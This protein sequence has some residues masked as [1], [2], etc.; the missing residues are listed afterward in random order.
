ML[1]FQD[2]QT[3][4]SL[5]NTVDFCG[6]VLKTT[7]DLERTSQLMATFQHP[8]VQREVDDLVFLQSGMMVGLDLHQ[9]VH[10]GTRDLVVRELLS[11]DL[12]F[13]N[14]NFNSKEKRDGRIRAMSLKEL[15]FKKR[16]EC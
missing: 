9:F 5:F 14:Q 6:F 8:E 11:L 13:K 1:S 7:G 15:K 10:H 12:R 3:Y 16:K 2:N 4:Q